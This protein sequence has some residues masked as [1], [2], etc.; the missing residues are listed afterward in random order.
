M[1]PIIRHVLHPSDFSDASRAAF[2]HAL[3][4]TLV[5][6]GKLTLIH[7]TEDEKRDW[8]EFPGVREMLERW[9][10]LPP[11]SS[12]EAVSE[13]GIDVAKIIGHGPDPVAGVLN[14]LEEHT[15][16]VIV[17]ATHHHGFDWLHKSVSEPVARQSRAMTLFVPAETHR[18]ISPDDG[19]ISLRN[20]LIPIAETPSPGPAIAGAA[21]IV[22]QLKCEEGSFTLLHVGEEEPPLTTPKV[23]GWNW[24]RSLKKGNVIDAIL[25]TAKQVE[26]DLI[27]MSTD[28]RN[29]FLDTLRGSHSERVLRQAQCP[30][31]AI[32][33]TSYTGA[34]IEKA[35][36]PDWYKE[37]E[38]PVRRSPKSV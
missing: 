18:F 35:G 12:R 38:R 11:G 22:R 13:L 19:S 37:R 3:K 10:I 7:M 2:A 17:L 21:R 31:L 25:E 8:S 33:E 1:A 6:K 4:A 15:A 29:G 23:P 34:R 28:G 14:Y 16:D 26:A 36:N 9:D 24:R 5:A 20:I 30:V 27:V 32:P